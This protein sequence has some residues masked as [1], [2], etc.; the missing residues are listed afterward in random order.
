MRSQ[1]RRIEFEEISQ[2]PDLYEQL[3]SALAPSV[4]EMDDVKKV[5]FPCFCCPMLPPPAS[6]GCV[7][8]PRCMRSLWCIILC[9]LR[10]WLLLA[11]ASFSS[12]PCRKAHFFTRCFLTHE[13]HL[14][15]VVG[16][17]CFFY[18][19]SHSFVDCGLQGVL[20]QLFGGRHKQLDAETAGNSRKRGEI[21]V[22]SATSQPYP[23]LPTHSSPSGWTTSYLLRQ[24]LLMG[25][26]GTSKS[27]LLQY[28]HKAS[29]AVFKPARSYQCKLESLS[30]SSHS[31]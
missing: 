14:S 16:G 7:L 3:S 24:V 28:V 12:S 6:P 21:N 10:A 25:D 8:P 11:C 17:S 26:P 2:R 9:C 20:L 15:F 13:L 29:R 23:P 30:A 4:W 27:Q 5:H 22:T 19:F 31:L 18:F 1:A